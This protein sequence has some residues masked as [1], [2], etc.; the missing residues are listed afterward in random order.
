M[1]AKKLGTY[2][3]MIQIDDRFSIIIEAEVVRRP[4]EVD[5]QQTLKVLAI[6]NSFSVDAMEYLYKIAKNYGINEIILRQSLHR[7]C[8]T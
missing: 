2:Y 5:F 7:R 8:R 3:L 6:G 4:I 1:T